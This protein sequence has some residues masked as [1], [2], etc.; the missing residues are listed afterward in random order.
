M[1]LRG[2]FFSFCRRRLIAISD[3]VQSRSLPD[4]RLDFFH[5][6]TPWVLTSPQRPYVT[7][8]DCTFVD[9]INVYHRRDHFRQTDLERIERAEASWLKRACRVAFTSEWA[10]E[11]ARTDYGLDPK[12]IVVVGIFGE[13]EV[14]E[15]DAYAGSK[16]FAF[17]STDFEAKGGPIA[18]RALRKVRER[19]P[20]VSLVVIG[21]CPPNLAAVPGVKSVGFLRKEVSYEYDQFRNIFGRVRALVH[22]TKS[23][24]AP[25]LLVEAGYFG[26]PVISCRKFAIPEIIDHEETGILLEDASKPHAIASAMNRML[27]NDERYRMIR[28]AAWTRSREKYSK[29]RF[30]SRLLACLH[31]AGE[32]ER[33]R[34]S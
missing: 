6:F 17:I 13:I 22:P 23:D 19:N 8:S 27:E 10:A 34:S 30:E 2:D 24:I 1:G 4:A 25:L 14:P 29:A 5:G 7:W 11:H 28:K 26:C 32:I 20:E 33:R 16:E 12:R 3:E 31:D 9:Y 21:D 18:V 15:Y